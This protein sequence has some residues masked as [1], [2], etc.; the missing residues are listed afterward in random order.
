MAEAFVEDKHEPA[1]TEETIPQ[2]KNV[3]GFSRL[4]NLSMFHPKPLSTYRN[5]PAEI[6]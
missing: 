1:M 4:F 2:L 5:R 6:Q 3:D